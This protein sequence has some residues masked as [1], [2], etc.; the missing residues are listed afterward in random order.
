LS[1]QTQDSNGN[2]AGNKATVLEKTASAPARKTDSTPKAKKVWTNNDL[3]SLKGSVP[4][5]GG[6]SQGKRRTEDN[7]DSE[8]ENSDPHGER[9]R[10]YRDQI[11]QLNSQITKPDSKIAQLKGFKAEN[12]SAAGGI[13]PSQGYNMVPSEAQVRQQEERKK[14]LQAQ[15]EDLANQARKEGID[16]GE[17]R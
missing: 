7:E 11:D 6:K 9:V 15:I 12:T 3:G 5:V 17:L 10:E 1:A 8:D 13:S 4:V 2:A 14:Q 16:P